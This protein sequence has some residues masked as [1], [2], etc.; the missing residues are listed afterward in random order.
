MCCVENARERERETECEGQWKEKDGDIYVPVSN[1]V[2]EC[3]WRMPVYFSISDTC[4]K[5]RSAL[6]ELRQEGLCDQEFMPN[7][8]QVL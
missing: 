4:C 1:C 7:E 6:A 8:L 3:V 2:C 5:V